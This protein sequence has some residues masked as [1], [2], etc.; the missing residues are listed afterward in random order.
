[1][2]NQH[3]KIKGYRELS[4]EELALMNEAKGLAEKC[5]ALI[6]KLGAHP[7]TDKRCVSLSKT[8]LQQGFMWAVRG[9]ARPE[10]F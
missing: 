1:M 8:Q 6:E 10:T 3:R 7:D 4:E 2:E 5:G 9:V